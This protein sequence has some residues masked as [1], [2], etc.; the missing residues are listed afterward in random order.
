MTNSQV[1]TESRGER[2][3]RQGVVVS[4]KMDK[5]VVVEIQRRTTHPLYRKTITRSE[6]LHVHD[7][8]NDVRVGD[9][10]QVAETRPLS[11]KKRWRVVE[12]LERAK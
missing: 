9:R 11:K 2:K 1:A 12:V 7:E 8:I 10:V 3:L 4:D 5:T 6:K